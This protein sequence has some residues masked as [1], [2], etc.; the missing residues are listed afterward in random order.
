MIL[1][2]SQRKVL[3]RSSKVYCSFGRQSTHLRPSRVRPGQAQ[4]V[5]APYSSEEPQWWRKACRER[6]YRSCK[7]HLKYNDLKVSL[8]QSCRCSS[9]GPEVWRVAQTS[10]SSPKSATFNSQKAPSPAL[11]KRHLQLSI[12]RHDRGLAI[13]RPFVSI[14][15]IASP[16]SPSMRHDDLAMDSLTKD[17]LS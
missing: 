12:K 1:Q 7:I 16:G 3:T 15:H 9:V 8:P 10:F 11:K 2:H 13:F 4:A 6:Y 5:R 17:D 14:G